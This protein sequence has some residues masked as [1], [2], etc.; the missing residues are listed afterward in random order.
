MPRSPQDV[1]VCNVLPTMRLRAERH[2]GSIE[3]PRSQRALSRVLHVL[4][5]RGVLFALAMLAAHQHSSQSQ[6]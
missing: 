5:Y 2:Y 3:T 1:P 4:L 6:Y